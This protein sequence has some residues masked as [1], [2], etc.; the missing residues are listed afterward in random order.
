[1]YLPPSKTG[2]LGQAGRASTKPDVSK[3]FGLKFWGISWGSWGHFGAVWPGKASFFGP[4]AIFD[5]HI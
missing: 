1:M 3:D 5:T 4:T 2:A